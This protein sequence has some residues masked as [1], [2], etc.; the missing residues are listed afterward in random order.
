[1]PVV[2]V[3]RDKLFHALGREYSKLQLRIDHIRTR[4]EQIRQRLLAEDQLL[5]TLR[6]FCSEPD[7]SCVKFGVL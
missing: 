4:K 7:V 2:S 6:G 1:M 5:T 3:G